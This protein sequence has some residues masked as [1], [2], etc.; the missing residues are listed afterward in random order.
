MIIDADTDEIAATVAVGTRPDKVVFP[1]DCAV[2]ANGLSP[3]VS[4]IHAESFEEIDRIE[5]GAGL[6]SPEG[7][8]SLRDSL[9]GHHV[10]IPNPGA[11]TVTILDSATREVR[12]TVHVGGQPSVVVV[13]GP[14]GGSCC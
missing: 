12:G 4:I 6:S 3:D 9:D 2:I 7:D 13:A 10:Y 8:R 11:G 1:K 5:T 14:S